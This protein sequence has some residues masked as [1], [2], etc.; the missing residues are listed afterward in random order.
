MRKFKDGATITIEPWRSGSVPGPQRPRGEPF[1]VRPVDLPGGGHLGTQQLE[2]RRQRHSDSK[3]DAA[4]A[5]MDAAA[6]VLPEPARDSVRERFRLTP[7][8]AR[9]SSPLLLQGCVGGCTLRQG[10]GRQDGRTARCCTNTGTSGR[11]VECPSR[12][13]PSRTSARLNRDLSQ[14]SGGPRTDRNT[15]ILLCPTEE[16]QTD[17]GEG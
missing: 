13:S 14:N 2:S 1:I 9:V 16:Y 12:S 3:A 10:D 8:T 17:K 4:R 6:C 7:R 5:P 11:S 15:S